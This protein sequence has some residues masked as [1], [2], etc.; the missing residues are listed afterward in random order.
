VLYGTTKSERVVK[1]G[2]YHGL[3]L[4]LFESLEVPVHQAICYEAPCFTP[5]P[6]AEHVCQRQYDAGGDCW[7]RARQVRS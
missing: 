6:G 3:D 7:L 2:R 5:T 4:I 1:I